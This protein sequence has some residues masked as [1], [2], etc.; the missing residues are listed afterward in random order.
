MTAVLASGAK[1]TNMTVYNNRY[2]LGQ[3]FMCGYLVALITA[4]ITSF[5]K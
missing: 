2:V 3:A 4:F 1:Q 5:F